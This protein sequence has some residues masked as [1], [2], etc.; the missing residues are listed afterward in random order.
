MP[1]LASLG[2][3][4]LG[5]ACGAGVFAFYARGEKR[6]KRPQRL[7]SA[8]SSAGFE[9]RRSDSSLLDAGAGGAQDS[10]GGVAARFRLALS[11]RHQVT[12]AFSRNLSNVEQTRSSDE[13]SE[14]ADG[15]PGNH[16]VFSARSARTTRSVRYPRERKDK[17]LPTPPEPDSMT[18]TA[19]HFLLSTK[20]A[21]NV[22]DTN[23]D[24]ALSFAEFVDICTN[25]LNLDLSVVELRRVFSKA[26]VDSNGSISFEEFH[27]AVLGKAFFTT[28]H[29]EILCGWKRGVLF[30]VDPAYDYGRSTS[31]N[32]GVALSGDTARD[33]HGDFA[34]IR[35]TCDY[36]Y[37]AN[38]TKARQVW[39]D[40]IIKR[41]VH[42]TET[43]RKP[44]VIFTCG[45]MGAGK[46][47]TLSWMSEQGYFPIECLVH[48]D[49][50]YFKTAMPE[51]SG[52]AKRGLQAGTMCHKES[53]LM[54]EIAQEYA[55]QGG[56]HVWVDG[57]LRDGEWY[58]KVF[59]D[60]RRR[61]PAYRIAII[62]VSA[63]ADKVRERCRERGR[64]TGREVPEELILASLREPK[65][66]LALLAP[67]CDF[68]ARIDNGGSVP[69]L[70]AVETV[71]RSRCWQVI[72]KRF[73]RIE[74]E[75]SEFPN[76]LAPVCMYHAKELLHR[77]S[78]EKVWEDGDNLDEQAATRFS[79]D[80]RGDALPLESTLR[81]ELADEVLSL[82]G[83]PI[84]A[85][86]LPCEE[87]REAG[88][89]EA[90]VLFAWVGNWLHPGFARGR[91][92]SRV[93]ST[94]SSQ[95]CRYIGEELRLPAIAR[96]LPE[97]E[98]RDLLSLGAFAYFDEMGRT[99]SLSLV[100]AK[101]TSN[102]LQFGAGLDVP[103]DTV[104]K[105]HALRRWVRPLQEHM[106]SRGA[107]SYCWVNPSE[108][109]AG[110]ACP[111]HGG[112]IFDLGPDRG[113]VLFP[114]TA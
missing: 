12:S 75:Y 105:L 58:A 97:G 71:D 89:P 99:V 103:K 35:A 11:S 86:T 27:H 6:R 100:S 39:Q 34:A 23:K 94:L 19:K 101:Y 72:Q 109:I 9:T 76:S 50:D 93:T 26:D 42:R 80:L 28:L 67:K 33:F 88:I 54:Q 2:T 38:V 41:V 82:Q 74:V 112:F 63:P 7:R 96:D 22:V 69:V 111:K 104:E 44:W 4:C 46:G 20:R 56:Q 106:L 36:G 21:F 32:Y 55:M 37:H 49:P 14:D 70:E 29:E 79:L 8:S 18:P 95:R 53:A 90:A 84:H 15:T 60:I 83:S 64:R 5:S 114:V 59:D 30:D 51:F 52:Y 77:F 107:S 62:Y 113:A 45:P 98:L 66:S 24:G 40:A 13:G 10:T 68:L 25:R 78:L 87:R 73:A 1:C 110:M 16:S 92:Y 3:F 61:F 57:S 108:V 91:A 48:V 43:Q 31:E 17:R 65:E 85:V 102:V 81:R 47:W